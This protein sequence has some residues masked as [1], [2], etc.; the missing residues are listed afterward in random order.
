MA[1]KTGFI[2]RWK[3]KVAGALGYFKE[4]NVTTKMELTP[5]SITATGSN[6]AGGAATI[7]GAMAIIAV[8]SASSRGIILPADGNADAAGGTFIP[9]CNVTAV[10][11]QVY[12]PTGG[13]IN[14]GA[15]NASIKINAGKSS[16]LCNT[17]GTNWRTVTGS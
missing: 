10:N 4:L 6:T 9:I 1:V 16:I 12:P 17:D 2:S 11:C 13:T 3:G 5:A 7:T 8:C 14:G 15:T